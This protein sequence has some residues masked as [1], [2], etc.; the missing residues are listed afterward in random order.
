MRLSMMPPVH[1]AIW[2]LLLAIRPCVDHLKAI[3]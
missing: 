1:Q 3:F 2:R